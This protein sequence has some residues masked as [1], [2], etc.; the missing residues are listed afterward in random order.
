MLYRHLFEPIMERFSCPKE[1]RRYVIA[2]YVQGIMGIVNEWIKGGCSEEVSEI[3]KIITEV[4]LKDK[5][6]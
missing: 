3:G 1:K 2:F 5:R 4:V 6:N